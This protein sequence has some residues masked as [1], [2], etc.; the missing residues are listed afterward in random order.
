MGSGSCH[1][2]VDQSSK[3]DKTGAAA[4]Q[5]H[6]GGEQSQGSPAQLVEA[7]QDLGE[8]EG[9]GL[10]LEVGRDQGVAQLPVPV[11]LSHCHMASGNRKSQ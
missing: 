6:A 2:N 1:E 4:E 5:G 7:D 3:D 10:H 8:D 11:L 9:P